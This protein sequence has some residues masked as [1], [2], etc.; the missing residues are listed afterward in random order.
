[1]DS[2]LDLD[3]VDPSMRAKVYRSK[4]ETAQKECEE[5]GLKLSQ[6]QARE[7]EL[8]EENKDQKKRLETL[9]SLNLDNKKN[10][11][12]VSEK[13]KTRLKVAREEATH[14]AE[15]NESLRKE[16]EEKAL[17]FREREK[18]LE[19]ENSQLTERLKNIVEELG[20]EDETFKLR[21]ELDTA[22]KVKERLGEEKE[23]LS[24]QLLSLKEEMEDLK[25]QNESLKTQLEKTSQSHGFLW[26]NEASDEEDLIFFPNTRK[27]KFTRCWQ[28]SKERLKKCLPC[29]SS[30]RI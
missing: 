11:P 23:S 22:R 5:I 17:Q 28:V 10:Q 27:G 13:M 14:Y 18:S 6:T 20:D 29:Q 9:Y 30:R 15:E 26:K 24:D 2:D 4:M 21:N 19:N 12:T 3:N 16:I 1:M 7:K 25:S 8:I